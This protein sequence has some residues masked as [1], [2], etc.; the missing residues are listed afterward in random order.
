MGVGSAGCRAA[1]GVKIFR[2]FESLVAR[3]IAGTALHRLSVGASK[4]GGDV[5]DARP[6]VA[7]GHLAQLL[8]NRVRT[9]GQLVPYGNLLFL[10]AGQEMAAQ[11]LLNRVSARPSMHGC[12]P[13]L[14]SIKF[15]VELVCEE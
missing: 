13:D 12:D 10:A 2:I 3:A 6:A 7:V 9:L 5:D 8:A 15:R 1:D 4:A 11:G 14:R